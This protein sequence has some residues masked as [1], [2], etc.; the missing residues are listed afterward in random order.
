MRTT[1]NAKITTTAVMARIVLISAPRCRGRISRL[2]CRSGGGLTKGRRAVSIGRRAV[3]E[4]I[5]P[6]ASLTQFLAREER[7]ERGLEHQ[8]L[9][10]EVEASELPEFGEAFGHRLSVHE[11]AGGSDRA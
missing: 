3:A 9:D 5:E 11:V 6:T 7:S 4:L 8:R 1:A 2:P 10:G